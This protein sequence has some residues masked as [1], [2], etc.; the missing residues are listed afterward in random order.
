MVFDDGIVDAKGA[1]CDFHRRLAIEA[2]DAVADNGVVDTVVGTDSTVHHQY[3]F[4][5][6]WGV[7]VI[8]LQT[9]ALYDDGFVGRAVDDELSVAP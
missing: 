4:P 9:V 1:F 7:L 5:L 6:P 8:A 3:L 2:N